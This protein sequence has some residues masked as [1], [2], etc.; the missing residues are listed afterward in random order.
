MTVQIVKLPVTGPRFAH[1]LVAI[2]LNVHPCDAPT[3]VV[4]NRRANQV[5]NEITQRRDGF[6]VHHVYGDGDRSKAYAVRPTLDTALALC[7]AELEA[8]Y[9][10]P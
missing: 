10:T 8:D 1:D 3:F 7:V 9:S 2:E 6:H 4:F 5:E